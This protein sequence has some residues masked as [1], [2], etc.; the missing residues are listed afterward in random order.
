MPKKQVIFKEEG[1][2]VQTV[3]FSN[4]GDNNAALAGGS[5]QFSTNHFTLPYFGANSGVK[6][7]IISGAGGLGIMEV[8]IQGQLGIND[9]KQLVA[10]CKLF[11]INKR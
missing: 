2:D 4:P 6:M 5:I 1:L 11:L 9:I 7:Q 8:I 10:Y 3:F